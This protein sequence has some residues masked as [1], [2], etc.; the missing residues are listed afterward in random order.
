M[1]IPLRPEIPPAHFPRVSLCFHA[2][3]RV[4]SSFFHC[5]SQFL[6]AFPTV[7]L[8]FPHLGDFYP[9][10]GEVGKFSQGT[11]AGKLCGNPKCDVFVAKR[12]RG[13]LH[14]WLGKWS[15][16]TWTCCTCRQQDR[17]WGFLFSFW[18]CFGTGHPQENP[19]FPLPY[20]R[21][22]VPK[23]SLFSPFLLPWIISLP[24][25]TSRCSWKCFFPGG[26]GNPEPQSQ[27]EFLWDLITAPKSVAWKQLLGLHMSP[28]FISLISAGIGLSFANSLSYS[29]TFDHCSVFYP[30]NSRAACK[31]LGTAD[32]GIFSV[33]L[34]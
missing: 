3:H 19:G 31:S 26:A 28:E 21:L 27:L 6:F 13:I 25:V 10:V 2:L 29:F 32:L 12:F 14:L 1:I 34:L 22:D 33:V 11:W 20:P 30:R 5:L 7:S 15:H 24:P 18:E 9:W 8:P 4:F 23:F 16:I 17:V